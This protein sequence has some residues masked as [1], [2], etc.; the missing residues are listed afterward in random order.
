MPRRNLVKEWAS[1]IFCLHGI[2]RNKNGVATMWSQ[3]MNVYLKQIQ[4]SRNK[5]K[6][7]GW[8]EGMCGW[9][10]GRREG[11]EKGWKEEKERN[12]AVIKFCSTF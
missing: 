9:K 3:H 5:G 8:K 10:R 11:R 7:E 1:Q 4:F 2:P 6:K 12:M